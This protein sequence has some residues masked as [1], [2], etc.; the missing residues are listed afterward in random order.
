MSPLLNDL[1]QANDYSISDIGFFQIMHNP[2]YIVSDSHHF[3]HKNRDRAESLTYKYTLKN[4]S[5]VGS[6][7]CFQG[8]ALRFQIFS[9]ES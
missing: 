4:Q 1:N 3:I 5:C 2:D 7:I 9:I 6:Y 8:L